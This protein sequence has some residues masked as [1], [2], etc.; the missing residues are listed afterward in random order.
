M[1]FALNI[2]NTHTHT[3]TLILACMCAHTH[4]HGNWYALTHTYKHVCAHAHTHTYLSIH[5]QM[6]TVISFSESGAV[7]TFGKSKFAENTPN[8]FWV[9][10]DRV[11]Q[12]ACGD[13]HTA[14]VAGKVLEQAEVKL[15]L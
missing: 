4:T 12:V 13:E 1:I 5:I 14:L 6:K 7:F 11:L 8:K 2:G 9:K 15:H 10:N 3:Y